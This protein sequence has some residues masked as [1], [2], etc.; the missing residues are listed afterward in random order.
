MVLSEESIITIVCF[1][2]LGIISCFAK[3]FHS[4]IIRNKKFKIGCVE[5]EQGSP[6]ITPTPTPKSNPSDSEKDHALP[7]LAMSSDL[8]KN[9]N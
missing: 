5:L 2:V 6:K 8:F 7:K 4:L 1:C 3:C 9:K